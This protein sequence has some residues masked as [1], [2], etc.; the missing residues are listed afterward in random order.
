MSVNISLRIN[1]LVGYALRHRLI[2]EEDRI[3]T[4]NTLVGVLTV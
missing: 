2:T 4:V 1:Q 3:Y